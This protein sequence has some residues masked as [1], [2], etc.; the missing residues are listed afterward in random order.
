MLKGF[1]YQMKRLVSLLLS[2]YRTKEKACLRSQS[3]LDKCDSN[4]L[5]GTL[6][7]FEKVFQTLSEEGLLIAC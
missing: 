6:P 2:T 7:D 1:E 4:V 5:G 3:V